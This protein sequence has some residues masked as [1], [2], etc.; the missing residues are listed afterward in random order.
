MNLAGRYATMETKELVKI[1]SMRKNQYTPEAV[2]A[3]KAELRS[4]GE[5][6]ETVVPLL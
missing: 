2:R 6:N 5:T 1:I 3:A 4:R